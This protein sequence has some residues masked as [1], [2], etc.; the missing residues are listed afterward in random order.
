MFILYRPI[1]P[2]NRKHL[3]FLMISNYLQR[4]HYTR[5]I[6]IYPINQ[7]CLLFLGQY[8]FHSNRYI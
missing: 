2:H 3:V 4:L 7:K 5:Q 6:K 8:L 1:H